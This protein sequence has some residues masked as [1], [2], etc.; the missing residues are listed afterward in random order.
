MK[1]ENQKVYIQAAKESRA[2][3]KRINNRLTSGDYHDIRVEAVE[4]VFLIKH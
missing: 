1:K 4:E 3:S 2:K